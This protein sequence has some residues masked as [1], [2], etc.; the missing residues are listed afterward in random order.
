MTGQP[1]PTSSPHTYRYPRAMR[2]NG[3]QQNPYGSR[4]LGR[5]R[6]RERSHGAPPSCPR[7][8]KSPI[9]RGLLVRAG[10]IASVPHGC[11][12]DRS[13]ELRTTCCALGTESGRRI[14]KA[15][16]GDPEGQ[17]A[18][19]V[20]T[21]PRRT[22][23]VPA[24]PSR[25]EPTATARRSRCDPRASARSK[26]SSYPTGAR[27]PRSRPRQ[28]ASGPRPLWRFLHGVRRRGIGTPRV[29]ALPFRQR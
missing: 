5:H 4:V 1:P 22:Q 19:T 29:N 15:W 23:A 8:R 10:P 24:T 25:P 12:V 11:Q 2:E 3:S 21:S 18:R 7:H 14:R 9:C 17:L 16:T 26:P 13:A 20:W 28:E 27:R 6:G